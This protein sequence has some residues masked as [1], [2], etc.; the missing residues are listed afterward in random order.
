M[1]RFF[2]ELVL[3]H[4][5]TIKIENL[6]QG[7]THLNTAQD[8]IPTATSALYI[9]GVRGKTHKEPNNKNA[10]SKYLLSL[11]HLQTCQLLFWKYRN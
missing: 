8:S 10:F 6:L 5:L 1:L 9:S 2:H 7:F 11:Y 3:G 4:I